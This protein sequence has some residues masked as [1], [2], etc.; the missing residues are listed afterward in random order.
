MSWVIV[1]VGASIVGSGLYQGHQQRKMNREAEKKNKKE[2]KKAENI[3]KAAEL[4]TF[5]TS[6]R[7]AR[8]SAS[9]GT[10][11]GASGTILGG[12]VSLNEASAGTATTQ[13]KTL[14]GQ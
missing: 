2:M 9:R 13:T 12:G 10:G 14:L 6:Q 3:Q 11:S 1:A 8:V 5:N 4:N 7:A